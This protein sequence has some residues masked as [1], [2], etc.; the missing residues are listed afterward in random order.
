M[1]MQYFYWL[2]YVYFQVMQWKTLTERSVDPGE[3]GWNIVGN[4]YVPV[5]TD[6]VR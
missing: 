4:K 2:N 1:Y 5:M 6:E 3:C